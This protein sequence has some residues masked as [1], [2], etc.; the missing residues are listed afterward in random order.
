M[1]WS[2]PQL[3]SE[4]NHKEIIIGVPDRSQLGDRQHRDRPATVEEA[5]GTS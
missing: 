4:R 2:S 3:G 1:S 5:S